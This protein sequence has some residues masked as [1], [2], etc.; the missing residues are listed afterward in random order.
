MELELKPGFVV[1]E[2]GTGSGSMTVSLARSV[3][4][5]GRVFTFEVHEQR[6][7]EAANEFRRLGLSNCLTVIRRD[8]SVGGF[9]GVPNSSVDAVFLDLPAVWEAIGEAERTLRPDGVLATFSP[10]VEQVQRTVEELQKGGFSEIKTC[11]VALRSWESRRRVG[12]YGGSE[13]EVSRKRRREEEGLG[14]R[15]GERKGVPDKA[16]NLR[17]SDVS[18]V[19]RPFRETTSHTS[20]L[21][22]CRRNL[23]DYV[24][25]PMSLNQSNSCTEAQQADGNGDARG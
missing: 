23:D 1:L 21:T 24:S 11:T 7:K 19:T 14:N 22:F 20:F 10:C 17:K 3:S 15:A 2:S 25:R 8:V 6:A 18:V 16:H 9:S 5:G 13:S 4:P 12:D